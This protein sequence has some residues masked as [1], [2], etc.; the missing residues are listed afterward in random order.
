[1]HK[2]VEA[3]YDRKTNIHND[4]VYSALSRRDENWPQADV[5]EVNDEI[6]E[7]AL[8]PWLF[9]TLPGTKPAV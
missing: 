4:I 3:Y 6:K 1:M 5:T 2:S 7:L 8:A 9:Q